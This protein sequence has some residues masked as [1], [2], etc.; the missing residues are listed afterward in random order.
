MSKLIIIS[1]PSG[2]GKN[3]VINALLPRI[4]KSTRLITTTTR[5]I[6]PGE[7]HGVDYYFIP[8]E[9]FM[10]KQ[11]AGE[12]LEYNEYAGNLYGTDKKVLEDLMR[13]YEVVFSQIEVHG[14]ANV[15]KT[16][17]AHLAIFLMPENLDTLESR[18]DKR[19]GLSKEVIAERMAIAREELVAAKEYDYQV[20]NKEGQFASTV[21]TVFD[22]VINYLHHA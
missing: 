10:S 19:G 16:G 7:Q 11:Q 14:R 1:S 9:E 18:I 8:R 3:S 20:V 4:P 6:R 15:K 17:I 21:E 2:G 12:F 22:L 13:T 5:P